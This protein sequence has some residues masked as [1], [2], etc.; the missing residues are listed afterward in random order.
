MANNKGA[1]FGNQNAAGHHLGHGRQLD[2]PASSGS[3]F[4][5][6]AL[7]GGLGSAVHAG[8][9]SSHGFKVKTGMHVLGAASPGVIL[10]GAVAGGMLAKGASVSSALKAGGTTAAYYGALPAAGA[11]LGS[12]VGKGLGSYYKK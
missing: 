10:G 6:G 9:N 4:A 1:E 2:K 8:L 3:A 12:K 11:L 5:I 7:T